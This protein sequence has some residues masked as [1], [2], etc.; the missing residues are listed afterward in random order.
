MA[1]SSNSQSSPTMASTTTPPP[2]PRSVSPPY[3]DASRLSLPLSASGAPYELGRGTFGVVYAAL[4]DAACPVAVKVLRVAPGATSS[5][6]P[7]R[8]ASSRHGAVAA[9]QFRREVRRYA[10]LRGVK[11][12]ARFYG[13]A[14]PTAKTDLFVTERLWGGS[15]RDAFKQGPFDP[16]STLRV[17]TAVATALAELHR[18]G[19][20]HGDIKPA[21]ILFS[22][23]LSRSG[24]AVTEGVKV[25]LVDFGLSRSFGPGTSDSSDDDESVWS[26][27]SRTSVPARVEDDRAA[28]SFLGPLDARGTPAYLSPEA[29]CGSKALA[30]REVAEKA[31]V[32]ALAMLLFELETG[33]IPWANLSEWGIFV[34][35]CNQAERPAWPAAPERVPG[36]RALAERC[37]PHDH[38]TRLSCQQVADE[39]LRL[40]AANGF[41]VSAGAETDRAFPTPVHSSPR[42]PGDTTPLVS[43]ISNLD[44]AQLSTPAAAAQQGQSV[45]RASTADDV[46]LRNKAVHDG[47]VMRTRN[48]ELNA[49]Q[50]AVSH[51]HGQV[52]QGSF[53]EAA[54]KDDLLPNRKTP[55][56]APQAAVEVDEIEVVARSAAV[57]HPRALPERLRRDA[58]SAMD[59]ATLT[60]GDA[61][62][63]EM[64]RQVSGEQLSIDDASTNGG[65]D[66]D[67]LSQ[68]NFQ[69]SSAGTIGTLIS[70]QNNPPSMA[71]DGASLEEQGGDGAA[72][73]DEFV[74]SGQQRQAEEEP[75]SNT[76]TDITVPESVRS[77]NYA[78]KTQV[79][80]N[81]C[82]ALCKALRDNERNPRGATRTLE[83]LCV[84][85]ENDKDNCEYFVDQGAMR[86][87]SSVISRYGSTDSRL[88]KSACLIVYRMAACQSTK[89]EAELRTTGACEIVLNSIRWH[90]ANLPVVQNAACAINILCCASQALC[91]IVLA[92]GGADCALRVL[93]RG[94]KSF[95]RDVPVASAGLEVIGLISKSVSGVETLAKNEA[96]QKILECCDI[97]RDERIDRHCL[98]ILYSLTRHEAGQDKILSTPRSMTVISALMERIR[99]GPNPCPKLKIICDVL[100]ALADVREAKR[101]MARIAFLSSFAGEEVVQGIESCAN[102]NTNEHDVVDVILIISGFKCFRSISTLGEDVCGALQMSKVFEVT[103]TVLERFPTEKRIALEAI[104][105]L[106]SILKELRGISSGAHL[107]IVFEVLTQLQDRWLDDPQLLHSIEEAKKIVREASNGEENRWMTNVPSEE[108][109]VVEEQHRSMR[110]FMR[111]KQGKNR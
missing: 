39:V 63:E 91:S 90:P 32:Y 67:T 78:F 51:E 16:A 23:P 83:A 105:F 93:A 19:Y 71:Q 68:P 35:V 47:R 70:V 99:V 4:L 74:S 84:L 24:G 60:A 5:T 79:M 69:L 110:L 59:N 64:P 31:D 61:G 43:Y 65:Y 102:Q 17:A 111:K 45:P 73:T 81:D 21:N 27:S 49:E 62:A 1:F 58:T 22:D 29:W 55:H 8:D 46:A 94:S 38:R 109:P 108:S 37:W 89:A 72:H 2:S 87:V 77:L 88:C 106:N 80:N 97:F 14:P 95:G 104:L 28:A 3:L 50:D 40:R 36:L 33:T 53:V 85:L 25:K 11:G 15:L 34:A 57:A 76:R 42:L 44:N 92:L 54:N 56:L 30:D 96:V 6:H 41:V 82:S 18:I 75:I 20:T 98:G 103:R 13:M 7:L 66:P 10:A 9:R 100:S 12:V 86:T 101:S 52:L 107:D 48:K 26:F